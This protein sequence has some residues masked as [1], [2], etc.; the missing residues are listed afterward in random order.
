[1]VG[2]TSDLLLGIH[3]R[4]EFVNQN[5][6][7]PSFTI[8]DMAGELCENILSDVRIFHVSKRFSN[9]VPKSRKLDVCLV[10]CDYTYQFCDWFNRTKPQL[11]E[12]SFK[13]DN[14]S[15]FNFLQHQTQKYFRIRLSN[16]I[17]TRD[18]LEHHEMSSYDFH[19]DKTSPN[20]NQDSQKQK[21]IGELDFWTDVASSKV[22]L[23]GPTQDQT[24]WI[25]YEIGN[26][27][28]SLV[29]DARRHIRKRE[30]CCRIDTNNAMVAQ[31]ERE[32]NQR[33]WKG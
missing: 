31:D 24:R 3:L 17:L 14:I 1:M 13:D 20:A 23:N 10:S 30:F 21:R 26:S 12:P 6:I 4:S 5:K 25:D 18:V 8:F 33:I 28:P 15:Y 9:L 22:D 11:W 2:E 16:P 7:F 29:L 32:Q 19:T 27:N